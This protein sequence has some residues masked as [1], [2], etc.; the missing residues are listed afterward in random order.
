MKLAFS[1]LEGERQGPCGVATCHEIRSDIIETTDRSLDYG[2]DIW[3][4]DKKVLNIEWVD[5]E[6][7]CLISFRRGD[8]E[9]EVLAF[10]PPE[11][12]SP[13]SKR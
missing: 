12:L 2:L 13:S 6:R 9:R 11:D 8:W 3:F 5:S 10:E 1:P 4:D 7:V